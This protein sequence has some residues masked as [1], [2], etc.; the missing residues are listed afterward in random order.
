MIRTAGTNSVGNLSDGRELASFSYDGN[1]PYIQSA[2][3]ST[4]NS[5]LTIVFSEN[6]STL[7]IS[8]FILD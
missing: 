4:N 1:A 6:V 3:L 8:D 7:A 5:M 2:S